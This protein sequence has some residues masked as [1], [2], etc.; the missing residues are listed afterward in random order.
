MSKTFYH[1]LIIKSIS[2]KIKKLNWKY[3]KL[4]YTNWSL[5]NGAICCL[6]MQVPMIKNVSFSVIALSRSRYRQATSR[7]VRD[8]R[9]YS[10][11]PRIRLASILEWSASVNTRTLEKYPSYW[12]AGTLSVLRHHGTDL[13]WGRRRRMSSYRPPPSTILIQE[14][15]RR[16]ILW[17]VFSKDL[18]G[19]C[20]CCYYFQW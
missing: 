12:V 9:R 4:F 11:S 18:G 3:F 2:W 7:R 5:V 6:S 19:K 8:I 16:H 1:V 20:G 14:D 17:L 10:N 15:N 13:P